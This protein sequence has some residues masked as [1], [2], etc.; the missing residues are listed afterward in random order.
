MCQILDTNVSDI[1]VLRPC[2]SFWLHPPQDTEESFCR[3]HLA[4]GLVF[5]HHLLDLQVAL[6]LKDV[7]FLKG[8]RTL[9]FKNILLSFHN[10]MCD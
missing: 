3:K 6:M 5:I 9:K 8:I 7:L 2:L 1:V 4:T 10:L